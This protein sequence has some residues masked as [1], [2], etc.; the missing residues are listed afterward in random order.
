MED[1]GEIIGFV[2]FTKAKFSDQK[3]LVLSPIAISPDWQKGGIGS[4]LIEAGHAK[5]K[6]WDL[7]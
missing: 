4:Q 5:A 3:T 7:T 1:K 2:M 6:K